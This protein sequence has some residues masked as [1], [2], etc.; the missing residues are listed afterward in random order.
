MLANWLA[1]AKL[2][3]SLGPDEPWPAWS[4]GECLAVALILDDRAELTAMGYTADEALE[5]L[6]WDIGAAS[7]G[8]AYEV[9]YRLRQQ[10][11]R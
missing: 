1:K 11:N 5:R 8:E 4:T 7:V 2:A 10:I 6:R 3:Q 9:F